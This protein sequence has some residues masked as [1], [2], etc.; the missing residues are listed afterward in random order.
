MNEND[1]WYLSQRAELLAVLHLTRRSDLVVSRPADDLGLDLL[2][3]VIKNGQYTG[4]MFGVVVKA[5]VHAVRRHGEK[6]EYRVQ[7]SARLMA[8]FWDVPFPVCLFFFI[9]QN[10]AAYYVW[11]KEPSPAGWGL[12]MP[13]KSRGA[14][15]AV[16]SNESATTA[17]YRSSSEVLTS[18]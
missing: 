7:L 11:L 14:T 2:V 16:G 13:Y 1:T 15:D 12:R 18:G 9:M 4:R 6:G 5:S 3:S 10:D 8:S 17:R